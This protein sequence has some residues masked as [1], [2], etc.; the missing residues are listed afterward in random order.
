MAYLVMNVG[1]GEPTGIC[2]DV[3]VH[4]I[5]ERLGWVPEHV[6]GKNGSPRKKTPEDTRAALESW[7]PKDEWIEINPLLVGFGQLTCTPLRPKCHECPLAR[8]GSCPSA[9][10]GIARV[11]L[12]RVQEAKNQP[13]ARVRLIVTARIVRFGIIVLYKHPNAQTRVYAPV[14]FAGSRRLACGTYATRADVGVG[15]VSPPPDR[16]SRSDR[17]PRPSSSSSASSDANPIAY[18]AATTTNAAPRIIPPHLANPLRSRPSSSR[19]L[20]A[21]ASS[22]ASSASSVAVSARAFDDISPARARQCVRK[23]PH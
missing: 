11:A 8:D 21:S 12:E 15:R 2:V 1:W 14:V 13:Q 23:S 20:D 18:S 3:H 17:R 7:L 6:L 4:R 19:A 22:R 5:S 10:K 9:F 16:P